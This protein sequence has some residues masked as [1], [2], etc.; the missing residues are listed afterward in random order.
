MLIMDEVKGVMGLLYSYATHERRLLFLQV[1]LDCF[2]DPGLYNALT[3]T[4]L[5]VTSSEDVYAVKLLFGE[6]QRTD[7][8][9]FIKRG[10]H[11]IQVYL[12]LHSFSF[13]VTTDCEGVI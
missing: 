4:G 7:Q 6:H 10:I 1:R 3:Y 9:L 13:R 5:S 11:F 12:N 2:G 8:K